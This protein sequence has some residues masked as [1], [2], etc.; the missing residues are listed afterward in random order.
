MQITTMFDETAQAAHRCLINGLRSLY[1]GDLLFPDPPAGRPLIIANFVQTIDGIVSLKMPER[2]GGGEISGGNEEDIFIMGLLRSYADAVVIGEE[3]FRTGAGHVWTAGFICPKLE[4]QFLAL[5]KHLR[6]SSLYPLNVVVSGLGTLDLAEPLFRRQ[7]LHGIALTTV[8]GERRLK[9]RYGETLP[10]TVHVLPGDTVIDASEIATFLQRRYGVALL[11]NEGGPT[12]F[13]AFLRQAMLD[14][15][16]LTVAPQIVGRGL[17]AERPNFSGPLA[18]ES[19]Q[20][21]WG[22]LLSVRRAVPAGHLFLRY[23]FS[24]IHERP[25]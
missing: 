14:E 13:P 21:L 12:L 9:Q 3:T 4:S 11:L 20:S 7:D 5:R 19:G 15:M 17:R 18:L 6:K 16:F 22:T 8:Q 23:R 2:S 24:A 25:R 1:D 10:A